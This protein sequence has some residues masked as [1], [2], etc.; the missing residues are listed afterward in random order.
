M[1]DTK[2]ELELNIPSPE[3]GKTVTLRFPADDQWIE[4]MRK[5]RW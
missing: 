5:L 1:F 4:R 2:R 3:G